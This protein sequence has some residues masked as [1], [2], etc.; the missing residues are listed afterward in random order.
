M[1]SL[2]ITLFLLFPAKILT[3]EFY[4]NYNYGNLKKYSLLF[5]NRKGNLISI[6]LGI[7][8]RTIEREEEFSEKKI[9]PNP[10]LFS[11]ITTIYTFL[12]KKQKEREFFMSLM[13]WDKILDFKY[14]RYLNTV[15]YLGL[16]IMYNSLLIETQNNL[17]IKVDDEKTLT[18]LDYNSFSLKDHFFVSAGGMIITFIDTFFDIKPF[19][20]IVIQGNQY[21]MFYGIGIGIGF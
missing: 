1:F 13:F 5:E 4:Y 10:F 16:G 11:N 20:S 17:K 7:S 21:L 15:F 6:D 2:I 18:N 19:I 3:E 14:L 9:E 12:S 8:R